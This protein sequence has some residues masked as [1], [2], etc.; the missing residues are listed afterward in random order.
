M[1]RIFHLSKKK[2]PIIDDINIDSKNIKTNISKGKSEN[3]NSIKTEI[4]SKDEYSNRRNIILKNIKISDNSKKLI[5]K[6]INK[7]N[8]YDFNDLISNLK[9]IKL[10]NLNINQK[11]TYYKKQNEIH[12]ID[13]INKKTIDKDIDYNDNIFYYSCKMFNYNN[14]KSNSSNKQNNNYENKILKNNIHDLHN[15]RKNIETFEQENVLNKFNKNKIINKNI[16]KNNININLNINNILN[17]QNVETIDINKINQNQKLI[18]VKNDILHSYIN[19][20]KVYRDKISLSLPKEKHFNTLDNYPNEKRSTNYINNNTNRNIFYSTNIK[21]KNKNNSMRENLFKNTNNETNYMNRDNNNKKNIKLNNNILIN[22]TNDHINNINNYLP[23]FSSINNSNT[24]IRDNYN[25]NIEFSRE[26]IDN[27]TINNKSIRSINMNKNY[28]FRVLTNK[29]KKLILGETFQKENKLKNQNILDGNLKLKLSK[30]KNKNE[31]S[32]KTLLYN[33]I[34]SIVNY[35]NFNHNHKINKPKNYFNYKITKLDQ[36]K[37]L[38]DNFYILTAKDNNNAIIMKNMNGNENDESLY[39]NSRPEYVKE[40]NDE[41][42][43]N[44]LIEEYIFNKR[45]KLI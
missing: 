35:N 24:N 13:K 37:K 25:S 16:Q 31:H 34:N 9:T 32:P 38:N 26:Y 19:F 14:K 7:N 27:K 36:Q 30:S 43:I 6:A 39:I 28:Y 29:K 44:L 3:L 11:N 5:R 22:R 10:N 20:G 21:I 33:D 2:N 40:Y 17:F 45:K 8:I 12:S 41:I 42:L 1:D 4:S 23:K 18:F 15:I